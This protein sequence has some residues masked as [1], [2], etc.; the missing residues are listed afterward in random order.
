LFIEDV[1]TAR[2][3]DGGSGHYMGVVSAEGGIAFAPGFVSVA[4]LDERIMAHEIGHNMSLKHA[5][6]DVF[7]PDPDYPNSTG[8]IDAWGYDAESEALVSPSIYFDLMSYCSPV[9]ISDYSFS[10]ALYFRQ[11]EGNPGSAPSAY[12]TRGLMIRGGLTSDGSPFLEPAFVVNSQLALPQ[13]DG[14]YQVTGE[15][16]NGMPLFTLSFDLDEIAD[17]DGRLF[18]G[19]QAD[20]KRIHEKSVGARMKDPV[21]MLFRT[22]TV[23]RRPASMGVRIR[24]T[25]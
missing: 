17:S 10:K 7:D 14:P 12:R 2:I 16:S 4:A 3:L 13:A 21:E 11:Q 22:A 5:P 15:D 18:N 8:S 1:Y 20:Q 19:T 6:C 24:N 23:R 25:V 9:W